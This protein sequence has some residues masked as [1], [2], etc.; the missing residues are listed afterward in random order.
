M[1]VP[2]WIRRP[3]SIYTL[4]IGI[5]LPTVFL[6][7][8]SAA[9]FDYF[10]AKQRINEEMETRVNHSLQVLSHNIGGLLEAYAVNEYEQII[11]NEIGLYD[12]CALLV[13]D[14]NLGGILGLPAYTTGN[15]RT[16]GNNILTF[17]AGN[18]NHLSH[19][20]NCYYSASQA[21]KSNDGSTIGKVR[22]YTSSAELDAK[23]TAIIQDSLINTL[24]ISTLMVLILI[25]MTRNFI[26]KP[27]ARIIDSINITDKDGIPIHE[28]PSSGPHEVRSLAHSINTMISSIRHSRLDLKAQKDALDYM[29]HHDALTGLANR[30]LFNDSL[31]TAISRAVRQ[32]HKL[33]VLFIDL[34]HF[35]TINE[36]L[37]HN[38]GDKVLNIITNRL[39]RTIR[40]EDTLA[41]MGGDEF[42]ILIEG[43]ESA[44][45]ASV[46]AQQVLQAISRPLT[47][48]QAEFYINC[49]IGISL[50]PDHGSS[51]SELLMQADAAMYQAKSEGRNTYQYFRTDLTA[52]A[53]ER[54]SLEA[55]LRAG[56]QNEE[57]VPYFQP[58]IDAST[59]RILGFEALARWHHPVQGMI[60]PG[61]FIPLAEATGLIHQLD[62]L[63]IRQAMQQFAR[64]YRQGMEPGVLSVN[65]TVRHFQHQQFIATL[66]TLI[67]DTGFRPEWLE[68]EVTESQLMIKPEATIEV[69]REIHATGIRVALDDF[70]T[71]YSSLSYLKR[72]PITKLKIDQSF[73]RDLPH[74]EEDIS[75][76]RAVIALAGSLGLEIIAE[77][78]ETSEQVDFLLAQGCKQIQGFFYS[79]PKPAAE[80][81]AFMLDYTGIARQA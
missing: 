62:L 69:L 13:D 18:P 64:W 57:L 58:Q 66:Q 48:E 77:G 46:P 14:F 53:L 76:V 20:D 39:T 19:L 65:L 75:I 17:E 5:I 9:T 26:L 37:G 63:I 56:L 43:L 10:A 11:A 12:N 44:E 72:L 4:L 6:T 67:N 33:A 15:L 50:F 51:A 70:G 8:A 68:I 35:K 55:Q 22:L 49:S 45:Q 81:E 80:A 25:L 74:D 1:Q 42:T 29:A 36:S 73:V 40:A 60:S 32:Q 21:I 41:R 24:I 78:A 71:G 16:A 3:P 28:V 31:N 23:L 2:P 79:R 34:D 59:G 38:T 47:I 54:I 52:Q 61:R 7:I 27:L 30:T